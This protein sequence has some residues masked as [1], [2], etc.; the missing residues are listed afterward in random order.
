MKN[1]NETNDLLSWVKTLGFAVLLAV[2]LRYFI[3]TPTVVVGASMM[4]TFENEDKIIVDKIGPKLTNYDR[5]DVVVFEFNDNEDYI[6][7]IIGLPGDHIE[8][9]N[10]SLF[11]NGEKYD[12]PYLDAYKGAL[13]DS[14]KLTAD[15]TLDAYLGETVVPEGHFFVLGDNRRKSLDSRDASVGFIEQDKII[16]KVRFVIYP[17][18]RM[19]IIK[20]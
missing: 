14:G 1:T 15:F 7:R 16:G 10:D 6:K 18:K 19:Q 11:I 2:G 8:Y 4:P 13:T 20:D 5:F 3:F 9:K 12:E 17:I